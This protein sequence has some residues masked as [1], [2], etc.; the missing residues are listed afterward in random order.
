MAITPEAK[1]LWEQA[2]TIL[3]R[4]GH[5]VDPQAGLDGPHDAFLRGGNH[6]ELQQAG[7]RSGMRTLL[8]DGIRKAVDGI[9]TVDEV[10]RVTMPK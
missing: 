1:V 8:A 7:V 10:L 6:D 3:L 9:T 2:E 4:G 5:L